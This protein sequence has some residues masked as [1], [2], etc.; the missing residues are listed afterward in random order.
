[1]FSVDI[2]QYYTHYARLLYLS[3]L[4]PRQICG[5]GPPDFSSVGL[6]WIHPNFERSYQKLHV[7]EL[8]KPH[9]RY[10]Q[11]PNH[12]S[13][14]AR[15]TEDCHVRGEAGEGAQDSHTTRAAPENE[16]VVKIHCSACYFYW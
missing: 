1:M 6:G 9:A 16:H 2:Y 8:G 10:F 14:P 15:P 3:P 4:G 7:E 11:S 12:S 5:P 13:R